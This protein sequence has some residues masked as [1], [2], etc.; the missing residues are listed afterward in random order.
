MIRKLVLFLVFIC[1]L[2]LPGIVMAKLKVVATLSGLGSLVESVGGDLVEVEVLASPKEDPHYVDARPDYI[3]KLNKA[4]VLVY[5]GME[6]EI[7]WLPALQKGARNSKIATGSPNAI[8]ASQYITA[9]E[10]PA[11]KVERSAGDI[12]PQGNPHY[13][14]AAPSAIA[15]AKAL[16]ERFAAI[17][18]QNAEVFRNN[19]A[20]LVK[21]LQALSTEQ[22]ARFSALP[23]EKRLMVSYH[24]S[25][26]YIADWLGLENVASIEP[27]PGVSP[28]PGHVAKVIS[29]M[30]ARGV[31]LILQESY[32][33]TSTSEKIAQ[34]TKAS[35]VILNNGPQLSKGESYESY[36]K[37][38][39]DAIFK[40]LD[41]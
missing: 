2:C 6:Y 7:G 20:A 40:A 39:T 26:V 30:R 37:K 41:V 22:I 28:N 35:I 19:A 10:V 1:T 36:L 17:D 15:I 31:R 5:N 3:L 38:L 16:G 8:D 4:D 24:A 9:L 25:M 34:M 29:T 18:P 23:K 21:S 27:K 13:L 32:Q 14:Y 12:H 11:T 33:P